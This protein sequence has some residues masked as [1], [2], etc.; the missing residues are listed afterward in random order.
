MLLKIPNW[1]KSGRIAVRTLSTDMSPVGVEEVIT[2]GP[3]KRT[4]IGAL[5][6]GARRHKGIRK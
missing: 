1:L 5:E 2:P 4:L 6:K 3:V